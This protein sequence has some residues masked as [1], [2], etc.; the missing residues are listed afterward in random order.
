MSLFN[1]IV[2]FTK[3]GEKIWDNEGL[4]IKSIFKFSQNSTDYFIIKILWSKAYENGKKT[5]SHHFKVKFSKEIFTTERR[6]K[7]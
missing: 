7:S 5:L 1:P 3:I 4:L 2:P 6:K